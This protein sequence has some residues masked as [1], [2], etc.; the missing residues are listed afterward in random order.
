ML[1]YLFVSHATSVHRLILGLPRFWYCT[2]FQINL[3]F[4]P[5]FAPRMA[6]SSRGLTSPSGISK[7]EGDGSFE[8]VRT[9]L[10]IF[11]SASKSEIRSSFSDDRCWVKNKK[12]SVYR[13]ETS[14]L[15]L[16]YYRSRNCHTLLQSLAFVFVRGVFRSRRPVVRTRQLARTRRNAWWWPSAAGVP[17]PPDP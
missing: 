13:A 8:P 7:D 5:N 16:F 2:V 1:A 6:A 17:V 14:I 15:V 11:L 10:K 9:K 12:G 3:T 4:A